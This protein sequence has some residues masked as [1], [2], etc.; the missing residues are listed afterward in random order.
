[1]RFMQQ[2]C[3]RNFIQRFLI[4]PWNFLWNFLEIHLTLSLNT[5]ETS[6]KHLWSC[7]E[8]PIELLLDTLKLPWI[9]LES[10]LWTSNTLETHWNPPW[11][12]LQSTLKHPWNYL[13]IPLKLSWNSLETPFK[14]LWKFV[15][16][17]S[18]LK[19]PRHTF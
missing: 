12:T 2:N 4:H 16:H 1:M 13:E 6:L 18:P 15:K 8:T 10:Y 14:L 7:L 5:L 3:K 9:T 19:L 11:N 17:H